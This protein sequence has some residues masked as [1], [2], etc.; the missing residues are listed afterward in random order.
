M[1]WQYLNKNIFIQLPSLKSELYTIRKIIKPTLS[2]LS[3]GIP[4]IGC[5]VPIHMMLRID[6]ISHVDD[7]GVWLWGLEVPYYQELRR[8]IEAGMVAMCVNLYLI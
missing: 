8:L 5:F 6:S 7:K 3:E 4:S 1:E 2:C